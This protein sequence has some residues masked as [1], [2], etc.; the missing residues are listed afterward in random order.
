MT[1]DIGAVSYTHLDV[2]KRQVVTQHAA[3][4]F[5]IHTV[6]ECQGCECM[7]QVVEPDMPVS[8]THLGH[9]TVLA[10]PDLSGVIVEWEKSEKETLSA[11]FF[12]DRYS[13][14]WNALLLSLI[15]ISRVS[16]LRSSSV[17]SIRVMLSAGWATT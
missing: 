12:F 8:Y 17:G 3:D 10:L 14:D 9:V 5:H 15:H 1:D 16:S 4:G 11:E 6:L 7:S 13:G 2:Y